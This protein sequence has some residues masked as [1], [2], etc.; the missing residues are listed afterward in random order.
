MSESALLEMLAL[1]I[2]PAQ[3]SMS[4]PSASVWLITLL[5]IVTAPVRFGV[6]VRL[7]S[8][9]MLF[10]SEA[11]PAPVIVPSVKL[12]PL[13]C[14]P[15]TPLSPVFSSR[16]FRNDGPV[17]LV[18]E[19]PWPVVFWIVPPELSPPC[20]VLPLPVTVSAAARAGVVQH[21]AVG[22]SAAPLP[23]RC[24]GRSRP[25]APMVVLATLSAVPVVVVE[26]VVRRRAVG[27]G[28]GDDDG[29]AAGGG[30]GGVGAGGE[31]E[32]AVEADGGGGVGGQVDA[33]RRC[34]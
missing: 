2:V 27:V 8:K 17:V 9:V 34:R 24:C 11:S 14:V 1:L 32:A 22:R 4:M 18:S 31:G 23:P 12:N 28:V 3:F 20:V 33:R 19:M 26:G 10:S 16:M 21:D 29:A 30:E 13:T 6:A 25:S 15:L 5:V 7:S